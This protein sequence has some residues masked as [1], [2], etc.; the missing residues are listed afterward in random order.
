MPRRPTGAPRPKARDPDS[1]VCEAPLRWARRLMTDCEPPTIEC[2]GEAR[3][4]SRPF[5]IACA[6]DAG[7]RDRLK[8]SLNLDVNLRCAI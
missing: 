4:V 1:D 2:S 7:A 3:E 8:L 6:G 5:L